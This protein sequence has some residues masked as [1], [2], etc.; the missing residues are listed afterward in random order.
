MTVQMAGFGRP[1]TGTDGWEYRLL[2][3]ARLHVAR[4]REPG[5]QP[6]GDGASGQ[7]T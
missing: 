5:A 2:R 1:G 6:G 7:A 3:L 4:W